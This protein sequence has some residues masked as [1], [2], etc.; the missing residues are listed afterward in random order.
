[1]IKKL[2]L[3]S[4]PPRML[5][6]EPAA[7]CRIRRLAASDAH[8]SLPALPEDDG[9]RED[10][11]PLCGAWDCPQ[12]SMGDRLRYLFGGVGCVRSPDS[13]LPPGDLL[14]LAPAPFSSSRFRAHRQQPQLLRSCQ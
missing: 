14:Q 5:E 12:V 11:K 9:R 2:L 4:A 7:A 1:M 3:L 8:S 6:C 13:P 10:G